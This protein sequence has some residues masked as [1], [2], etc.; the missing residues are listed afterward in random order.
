LRH[1]IAIG[2]VLVLAGCSTIYRS[3]NVVAGVN[4]STNVRVVA[5]TAETVSQANRSPYTPKTLPAIFSLTAGSG[6]GRVPRG[7]GALPEA[8]STQEGQPGNLALKVPPAVNPGPYK[9]G[10]GDVVVLA[11]PAANNTVEQLSG[12]LAAQNSRQGYTVQDDGSVNI[13]NVGRV[14]I[15]GMTVDEAEAELFQRLVENQ[16]DPTFSLEMSEFNSR[17]VSIGGAVGKPT[18]LP[19]TLTPLFLDEALAAAGGVGVADIDY[20]SVRIYRDGTLYQIPLNDLYSNAGLQRTRLVEGDSIFVDTDYKLDRA[21]AY[22][23]QQIALTNTRLL[24]RERALNELAVE[25]RLRRS[26]LVE[27]RENFDTRLELG[28]VNQ[29]YVYLFG[30]VGQQSRFV[31]PFE[32]Q[33]TLADALFDGAAGIAKETGDVSQVYVLRASSDP[34]EFGAVTAWHLNARNAANIV[35]ATRFQLRP[36]D[37]VFIAENP[38]TK[39]GRTIQ[40]ITPSLIT[41]A[42]AVAN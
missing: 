39:W 14:M 7:V 27:A 31:L 12:L 30:E 29:D 5:I 19:I 22:F 34:R 10:V 13:P 32:R 42:A 16:I 17:R 15:A 9:I 20:A 11:T 37:I 1:L 23:R 36:N 2:F 24:G 38:V 8:P 33:A 6:A 18:V 40:Q 3:P 21:E 4:D 26:D 25:I 35:L 41:T 28:A